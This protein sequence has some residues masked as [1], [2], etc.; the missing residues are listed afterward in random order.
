ML[1][2]PLELATETEKIVAQG[3]L[4]KY[5][6]PARAGKW[7]G[8]IASAD[9]CG[10]NLRCVFCWSSAPRDNI[11]HFGYDNSERC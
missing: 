2:D 9:C 7:Y 11:Q 10:C 6:R 3:E 1:Y 4:K 5:Y 8:G